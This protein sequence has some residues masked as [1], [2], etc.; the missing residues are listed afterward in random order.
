MSDKKLLLYVSDALRIYRILPGRLRRGYWYIFFLQTLNAAI[1]SSTILVISFFFVSVNSPETSRHNP[2]VRFAMEQLPEA[3]TRQLTGDRSFIVAMCMVLVCFIIL[4]NVM[5]GFSISRTTLFSERLSLFISY[6]TYRRYLY[7]SYFWHLSAESSDVL[8]RLGNRA[9]LTSLT[10]SILQ[11]FGYA[12][13][14]LFISV[15]LLYYQPYLTL[16]LLSVFSVVSIGVYA[17]VRRRIDQAGHELGRL[18]TREGGAV[19]VVT[20]GVREIIIYQKQEAFLEG[21]ISST[22]AMVPYKSFLSFAAMLPSWFLETAGFATIFS[23]MVALTWMGRPMSEIIGAI[24]LLFLSSWRI[25]P[26]VSRSMA[27]TVQI[28]GSRPMAMRCLELLED[29]SSKEAEATE[30]PDPD[31]RFTSGIDLREAGFRY[32]SAVADCLRNISLRIGKGDSVALVGPSGAGKSTLAMILAGLLEPA[33]GDMLV[34]GEPLTPGR[35]SAYRSKVGFVPQNP[36]LLP[37]TVADNVA[38]SRWGER[39]DREQVAEACRMAAM[40]FLEQD[41]RGMDLPIGAGGKGLSGGQ[42]Q[43]VSI[44]R[45]LFT[46]PDVLV[47]DEATSALDLGS[48]QAIVDTINRLSGKVTMIVIAH[49][50]SSVENCRRVIW[51]D[52]GGVVKEGPPEEILPE[53]TN[54]LKRSETGIVA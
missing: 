17:G 43:R 45:A 11:F 42:A 49:R 34:D 33:S 28:R 41:P 24:S 13:C 53:Y 22:R 19:T 29:F 46:D 39:Y 4:K 10:T 51:L 30:A 23:V 48:E 38:L 9:Q 14:C 35:R 18:S 44:A 54:S 37:G 47:F 21:I 15:T 27:L 2:L 40:D 8:S 3:W 31:F 7:K 20:H 12:L 36:L 16:T 32:P 52:S 5:T 6:E 26:A 1:E 25:L 50:L